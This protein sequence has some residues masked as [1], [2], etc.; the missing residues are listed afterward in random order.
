L[1]IEY[2]MI[3]NINVSGPI[4]HLLGEFLK[5]YLDW[6]HVNLIPYNPNFLP[7]TFNMK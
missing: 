3:Q 2:V 1:L 4:A 5:P 7:G 6:I